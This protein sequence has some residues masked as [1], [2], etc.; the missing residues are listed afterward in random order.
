MD[1]LGIEPSLLL[2]QIVNF[3]IIMVVLSKL[4]YKPILTMLEKRKK[5]IEE[6]LAIT[7]KMRTEEEKLQQRKQKMLE[8]TRRE[9]QEIIEEARKQAKEEEKEIL[10]D[11]HRQA[12]DVVAKG[13][14]EVVHLREGMEKGVRI[15]AVELAER[16]AQRLLSSV[17]SPEDKH[18]LIKKHL[19]ELESV[20]V[21]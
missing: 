3:T 7:E 9:A 1:K 5:E 20:N 13:R 2:A 14:A 18:K 11:A 17:L 12:E 6:G 15:S 19:K 10:A 4:L 8:E 21:S 16:M